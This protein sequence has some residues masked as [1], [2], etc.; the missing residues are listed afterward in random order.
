MATPS[1]PLP[2]PAGPDHPLPCPPTNEVGGGQITRKKPRA[3]KKL[4]L[5]AVT[6]FCGSKPGVSAK[7]ADGAAAL[8]KACVDE[9]ITVVYGGG[10]TGLMGVVGR[11]A[12]EAGGNVYGI[13]PRAVFKDECIG[14]T[15]GKLVEVL[16]MHERKG[17]M[18]RMSDGFIALPGG[19]GTMEE[20]FEVTT[21][22]QLGIHNKPVGVLNI[23][24]YYNKL[25]ELVD[26]FA[27]FVDERHR[28]V[29]IF[30]DNPVSLLRRMS[31]FNAP[32][33]YYS[34]SLSVDEI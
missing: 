15:Y 3:A 7:Y 11:T 26:N 10:S 4:N 31:N 13:V 17:L 24:G 22:L 28:N 12:E 8:A 27:G 1:I 21:W 25:R 9:N 30:D 2:A 19:L 29:I 5:K 20:L 34:R 23:D 32:K 16:T 18:N 33:P 14:V 6:I